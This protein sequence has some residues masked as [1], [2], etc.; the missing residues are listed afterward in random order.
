MGIIEITV[1]DRRLFSIN[2]SISVY[3]LVLLLVYYYS[4]FLLVLSFLGAF[5]TVLVI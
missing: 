1:F 5:R 2:Y 3:D 4:Y